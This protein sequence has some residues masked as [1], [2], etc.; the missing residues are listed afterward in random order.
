MRFSPSNARGRGAGERGTTRREDR[1]IHENGSRRA[2]CRA[3]VPL[4]ISLDSRRGLIIPSCHWSAPS[5]SPPLDSLSRDLTHRHGSSPDTLRSSPL[6]VHP[7]Y[8]LRPR[9]SASP[10]RSTSTW[11]HGRSNG[12][13]SDGKTGG[14]LRFF[15]PLF[16]RWSFFSIEFLFSPFSVRKYGY[17]FVPRI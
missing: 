4:T 15:L 7:F 13:I 5:A 12:N 3:V 2:D 16:S 1:E 17:M 6:P 14:F 9:R 8:L 11:V 10:F